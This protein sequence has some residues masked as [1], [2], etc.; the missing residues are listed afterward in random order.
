[1]PEMKTKNTTT[2]QISLIT[3]KDLTILKEQEQISTYDAVIRILLLNFKLYKEIESKE[4]D[5]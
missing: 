5:D 2:I 3:K 4:N 1:M